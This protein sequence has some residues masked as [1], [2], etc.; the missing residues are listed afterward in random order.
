M[1]SIANDRLDSSQKQHVVIDGALVQK[2][3]SELETLNKTLTNFVNTAST[4]HARGHPPR[5]Q[6]IP[7]VQ[8]RIVFKTRNF[9]HSRKVTVSNGALL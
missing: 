1:A 2:L 7:N 4:P 3:I 5:Y 9:T 8:D 6:G